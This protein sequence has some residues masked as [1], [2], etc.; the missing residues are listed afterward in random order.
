ML[1][2]VPIGRAS[3]FLWRPR[4]LPDPAQNV[5]LVLKAGAESASVTL[6]SRGGFSVSSSPDNYRIRASGAESESKFTGGEGDKFGD[7]W[8]HAPGVGQFPVSISGFDDSTNDFILS[9]P[10]NVTLPDSFTGTLYHNV[11]TGSVP[12]GALGASVNRSGFWSIDW[13]TDPDLGTTGD[14]FASGAFSD[15]GAL[16]VVRSI[17]DT[18]LTSSMLTTFV[19]ILAQVKPAGFASWQPLIDEMRDS[20]MSEVESRLPDDG[21]ADATLGSQWKRGAAL[22]LAAH[23]A[24]T[25]YAPNV[26]GEEMRKAAHEEFNRQASRVVWLDSDDDGV[27]ES[28]E[29]FT[30]SSSLVGIMRSS[31]RDTE[32][33]FSEGRRHRFTLNNQDDR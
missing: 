25:G 5:T 30:D 22:L 9:E 24:E 31:G 13:Q 1:F 17:F 20:V 26:S 33:D 4:Y 29:S 28:G 32:A 8:L 16:R 27:F 3:R 10:I 21:F 7:W 12:S 23:V 11:F 2:Q 18:G 6:T 14:A 15:R 19:P